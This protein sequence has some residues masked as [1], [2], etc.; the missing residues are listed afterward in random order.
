MYSCGMVFLK[1]ADVNQLLKTSVNTHWTDG[2]LH[3]RP[4]L[5]GHQIDAPQS[6]AVHRLSVQHAFGL[7]A[8]RV[9]C[10]G[11]A[12]CFA[13]APINFSFPKRALIQFLQHVK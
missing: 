1:K 7:E 12:R 2:T 11:S 8:A 6:Y 4:G 13:Q 9:Q 5:G 10:H 3:C